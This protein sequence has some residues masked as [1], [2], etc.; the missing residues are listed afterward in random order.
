MDS[1]KFEEIFSKDIYQLPIRWDG[2]DFYTTLY[3]HLKEYRE[4]IEKYCDDPD[5][6]VEVKTVC[7]NICAAVDFSFRGY[8]GKAYKSFERVMEILRKDPLLINKNKINEECLYRVVDVE[9]AAVPNRQRVFHVPFNMRSRMSTQRY[10]IP[11][12]PSLYLGTSVELCCM[13]LSK[14]PQRDYVC[15]SRY[16]L[17]TD[18]RVH[19]YHDETSQRPVFDNDEFEIFDV[20]IKPN[21]AKEKLCHNDEKIA[22]YMKWYPLISACSYIRA[23]RDA[24]YSAEYIIPQLFIQWVRSEHEDAVVGIKYF[25]CASVH[26]SGLG[27]NYVFPTIG[28]PHHARKTITHYC[29]R[30]SHRFK[31]TAP[32]F[33]MEYNSIADCVEV[34]KKDNNLNYIEDYG[35]GE[36]EEIE[37]DYTI[38]EGVSV[39][40]AYA[41]H[42][43]SLLTS[44]TIPDSVTG[45]GNSAFTDCSY[46][47]SIIIPDSV[48]S[49]GS[50]SFSGCSSLASI[51]IPGSVTSIGELTF[52]G[53]SSLT[54]IIINSSNEYY[55]SVDGILYN[56]TE[57]KLVC[58]PAGK[59]QTR[60]VIPSGV[61]NIDIFAFSDCNSL[62][63][64]IIPDGVMSIDESTFFGCNS[65]VN[66][67]IPGSVLSIG[68]GAFYNCS[69]LTSITIPNSVLNIDDEAFR[70]CSSLTSITIPDSVTRIGS[71]AF[72]DCSSLTSIIIPN[73]LTNIGE[74][75]FCGC[76]SLTNIIVNSLNEYY[77]SMD[78]ILYNKNKTKLVC[79]PA[80]KSQA[81]FTIP[82]N[83]TRIDSS[84]FYDCSSLTSITIPDSVTTIDDFA[85]FQCN[86]LTSIIISDNVTNIGDVAFYNC[87]SLG[88]VYYSGTQEQAKNIIIGGGNE[89][90]K[91]ATWVYGSSGEEK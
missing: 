83:V 70:G 64:I 53:C 59:K 22:K 19:S 57:T 87:S 90:L 80:G 67:S 29:A 39:I 82:S 69:S 36:N 44:I 45:I 86:S 28:V 56:K 8:P 25:S 63:S 11:G 54:N 51:N 35:V 20:S 24:P 1:T 66:V 49:I 79:Y 52:Y 85:F 34:I 9:S 47:T 16:E 31:L 7:R 76:I 78:G 12:F 23:M 60:F 81:N 72:T 13:E 41:F 71:G 27:Y 89:C 32:R 77:T 62:K 61:T 5:L 26:A 43:C 73:S 14:D 68:D 46:L 75:A 91:N 40:G 18:I 15:V 21:Q 3:K 37:G 50:F 88:T 38:P 30:L 48:T 4:D 42:G 74:F 58:Y 17:Q 2:K 33:I 6:F 10:S 55:T 84:A 65:L